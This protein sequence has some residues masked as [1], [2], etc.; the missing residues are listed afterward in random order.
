MDFNS[1]N[2]I[3]IL[4][5]NYHTKWQKEKGMRFVL[6]SVSG[7]VCLLKTR[8]TNKQFKT[9]IDDLIFIKTKHNIN[10]GISIAG[11][12]DYLRRELNKLYIN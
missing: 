9:N 1:N 3:I 2:E 4:G 12:C 5:C 6:H 11:G 10:K 8:R 7:S